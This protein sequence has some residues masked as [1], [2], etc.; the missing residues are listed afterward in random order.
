M[1]HISQNA[2]KR[3]RKISTKERERDK[4]KILTQKMKRQEF[5]KLQKLEL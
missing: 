5:A 4:E 3:R 1:K 2:S